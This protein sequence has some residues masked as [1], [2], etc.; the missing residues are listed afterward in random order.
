MPFHIFRALPVPGWS[1]AAILLAS[2]AS[3]TPRPLDPAAEQAEYTARSLTDPG[4]QQFVRAHATAS[5]HWNLDRVTWAGLY[6][7]PDVAI[8]RAKWQAARAA[9]ITAGARPN[10]TLGTTAEYNVDADR[11]TSPW[12]R[13]FNL[14]IPI[15]TAGKRRQRVAQAI[16]LAEA[17]HQNLADTAWLVRRQVRSGL[18]G[19]LSVEPYL[20][21][22][23]ALETERVRLVQ[24]RVD[25][26]LAAQPDL[27]TARLALQQVAV[28]ADEAHKQ[29]VAQRAAFASAIGLPVAA[30]DGASLAPEDLLHVPE[31]DALPQ[32]AQQREA[33]LRRPDVLAALAE[34]EASDAALR[35]EI[36]KQ[37]PDLSLD[38]GLLWD[39]GQ[40]KWTLGLS[41]VLP[42]LNQNKGP[43]AEA[44][45][46]REQAAAKV[47]GAQARAFGEAD[48]A[49]A[50]YRASLDKLHHADAL[51][52]DQQRKVQSAQR[53]QAVG[54][55]ERSTALG[56]QVELA[57]A[58]VI[59]QDALIQAAQALGALEDALR[60]PLDGTSFAP[61]PALD[62][63]PR[64]QDISQ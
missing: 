43:I 62:P 40:L 5:D 12:T 1:F 59:R 55:I 47:L 10:P 20:R 45:A 64:L 34:Y 22:Q 49:L 6:Y 37:Y 33:L 29:Q 9:A 51:V 30:L 11:G 27:V 31:F 17:A 39:A 48:Q 56:A 52:L 63:S 23:L 2:C 38:P 21:R 57:A 61:L 41:A 46:Q 28:T 13:G 18:L 4:L 60:R 54:E 36:A 3:Y 7:H 58:E 42:L 16:A 50:S 44:T 8:A 53:Q 14:S 19:T 26:G 35:L 15:E 25:L 24:R 32:V